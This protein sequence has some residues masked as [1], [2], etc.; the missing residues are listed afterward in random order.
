MN[1]IDIVPREEAVVSRLVDKLWNRRDPVTGL[2]GHLVILPSLRGIR[3]MR[4]LLMDKVRKE[5]GRGMLL[6]V[7]LN[8]WQ[9]V[10]KVPSGSGLVPL[11]EVA[12]VV[13]LAEWLQG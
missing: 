3:Q 7:G 5:G 10:E 9:V 13:R 12:R 6:P 8:L 4:Y 1:P 2:A 11:S